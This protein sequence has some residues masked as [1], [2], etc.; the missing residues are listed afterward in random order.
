MAT[1]WDEIC[2]NLAVLLEDKRDAEYQRLCL[3]S[4]LIHLLSVVELKLEPSPRNIRGLWG[5]LKEH[6]PEEY[7]LHPPAEK[8]N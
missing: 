2:C 4:L 7:E 8:K 3:G 1:E 5:L 6:D